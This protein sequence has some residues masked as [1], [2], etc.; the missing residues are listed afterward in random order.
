MRTKLTCQTCEGK[1]KD[2]NSSFTTNCKDCEGR[3]F[4]YKVIA[5]EAEKSPVFKVRNF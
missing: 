5:I 4:D 2:V 3:G 1:G